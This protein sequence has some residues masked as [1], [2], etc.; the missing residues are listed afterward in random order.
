MKTTFTKSYIL[1][2]KGY[3]STE[4]LETLPSINKEEITLKDLFDDLPVQD[5]I[6]FLF[7][8]C[9]LEAKEKVIIALECA[10]GVGHIF[11][12]KHTGSEAVS[13]CNK[14]TR[15]FLKGEITEEELAAMAYFANPD[16]NN[17]TDY[18]ADHAAAFSAYAAATTAVAAGN[19]IRADAGFVYYIDYAA[20]AASSAAH[21]DVVAFKKAL[22][23]TITNLKTK[24]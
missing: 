10:E 6:R 15:L 2:N 13:E 23:K 7:S 14:A 22:W 19:S 20:C 16:N 11:S 3:C 18:S 5:F 9:A 24:K 12:E 4:Q 8:A 21:A 17:A 1:D